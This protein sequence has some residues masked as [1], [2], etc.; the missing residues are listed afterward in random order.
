MIDPSFR[1]FVPLQIFAMEPV[2]T[3][4]V[5]ASERL[6]ALASRYAATV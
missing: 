5:H 1:P 6:A 2:S 3:D 4:I